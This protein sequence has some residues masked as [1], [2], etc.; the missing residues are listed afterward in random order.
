LD[1][2]YPEA[3]T[4]AE[5]LLELAPDNTMAQ[6]VLEKCKEALRDRLR[7]KAAPPPELGPEVVLQVTIGPSNLRMLPLDPKT[8]FVLSLLDGATDLD[9]VFSMAGVQEKDVMD[10]LADLVRRGILVPVS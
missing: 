2:D 4:M 9:T 6:A 3:L 10:K 1:S 5:S 7:A 8:M